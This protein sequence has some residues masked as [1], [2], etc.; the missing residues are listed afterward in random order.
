MLPITREKAMELLKS[1]PQ[2][3]SDM[4]HYIETEAIMKGL[5]K[6]FGE[7]EEYWGMLGL[8][9]DVDWSL[10]KEDWSQHTL[11]ARDILEKQG[12]DE[13]FIQI[14]QSHGYGYEEMPE[15]RDKKRTTKV[16]YAL[17]AAET[18]TGIIFAY[19]LLRGKKISGMKPK[20]VKKRFKDKSF[21]RNC[22]RDLIKEIENTGLELSEFFGIAIE[23]MSAIKEDIGLE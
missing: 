6:H 16:E 5:A 4:N 11:K 17:V 2:A 23:S 8:L 15:F 19:A 18:L 22:S 21:A 20:G 10:T 14:V 3:E 7:D 12:F 1:M 13:E 9:H